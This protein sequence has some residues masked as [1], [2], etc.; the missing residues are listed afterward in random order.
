MGEG[1]SRTRIWVHGI[2][3]RMGREIQAICAAGRASHL[4]LT[5]GSA[6]TIEG[7]P[8]F[9]GKT[10]T[11]AVL[12]SALQNSG[13][14]LVLDFSSA[15][16][17]QVLL[18]AIRSDPHFKLKSVLIG[19]TGL[20]DDDHVSWRQLAAD[21]ELRLLFAPNTSL[22]IL[23][24]VKA[25]SLIAPSLRDLGFDIEITETHHR[26]KLDAPSGTAKFLADSVA[27]AVGGLT[28]VNDRH[29]ERKE[30]ELGVHSVRGGG[31]FGEH[32]IRIIGDSEE[33]R[34]SHRAF[35]RN[36]FAAGA[37]VLAR[38]L[39]AQKTGVY[40]LLDIN[41]ADLLM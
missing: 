34:I 31:V 15:A 19:S 16:G 26:R 10:T 41:P 29:G 6:R 27:S 1:A 39:P 32:E 23:M 20:S 2:T 36:L 3:G 40:G 38:W 30:D 8:L 13:A 7:D 24:T 28:V 21:R 33:V 37:L 35:S 25:A 18:T 5:G 9:V 4:Q 12:A 22:G 14:E 11:P 17:N